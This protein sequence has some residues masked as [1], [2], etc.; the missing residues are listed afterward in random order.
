MS[1]ASPPRAKQQEA[2]GNII[3]DSSTW[4]AI[5]YMSWPLLLNMIMLSVSSFADVWVSG[6][7]GTQAQA[8]VGVCAQL[9]FLVLLPSNALAYGAT[10][11]ISRLWGAGQRSKADTVAWQC[12]WVSLLMG[13]CATIFGLL[14]APMFL[15]AQGASKEV[16]LVAQD[17]LRFYL[18]AQCPG[19]VHWICNAIFR[20]RGNA[21]V[22]FNIIVVFTVLVVLLE[23]VFCLGPFHL[24]IAGIGL[25]WLCAEI[26][27]ALLSIVSLKAIMSPPKFSG[28]IGDHISQS[29]VTVFN[30]VKIGFPAAL[31]ECTWFVGSFFLIAILSRLANPTACQAAWTIGIR[32]EELIAATPLYALMGS[33]RTII[34]QNLG[35]G[36]ADRAEKAGWQLAFIGVAFECVVA[37]GMFFF[38]GTIAHT[39]SS[40]PLVVNYATIFF[41]VVALSEPFVALWYVLFGAMQGAGYMQ[42]PMWVNVFG[43]I[44]VRVSA[45]ALLTTTMCTTGAWISIAGS[46]VIAALLAVW[47]FKR[48]TW[49]HQQ[50]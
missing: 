47:L 8:A 12:M 37:L 31:Q 17:Y 34:G 48:G 3:V 9:W 21:F 11:G 49:K 10:A 29:L 43:M 44:V 25:A 36:R 35:A 23:L 16:A 14:V 13:F 39:M 30:Y 50:I 24:G 1:T 7:L 4:A 32:M 6:K 27:A 20:A 18:L 33:A 22:P 2:P 42:V 5:W 15:Q 46:S 28:A 19:Y 26:V 40:D 41:Q 38:A 45:A